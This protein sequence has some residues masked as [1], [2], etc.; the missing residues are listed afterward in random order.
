MELI[1]HTDFPA[2]LLKL[3]VEPEF[4]IRAAVLWK[5]TYALHPTGE[6]THAHDPMPILSDRL[7]TRFGVFHAETFFQ[8]EDVDVVFAGTLRTSIPVTEANI[9]LRTRG[10]EHRMR[11]MGNRRWVRLGDRL[12]PSEPEPFVEMPI[13][14]GRAYGGRT[15]VDGLQQVF[16]ANPEGVGY[17]GSEAQADNMPLPNLLAFDAPREIGWDTP[18][19]VVGWGPYPMHWELRARE[20]I[21]PQGTPEAPELPRLR[22]RLNNNAHPGL[23]VAELHPGDRLEFE[24]VDGSCAVVHLPDEV[25]FVQAQV[26]EVVEQCVGRIDGVVWWHDVGRLT[27]THRA[28][29]SYEHRRNELRRIHVAS[30]TRAEIYRG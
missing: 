28:F 21:I 14:Y 30:G 23:I 25:L 4:P 3:E 1:N 2:R 18:L 7:E 11:V 8:K 24:G 12:V 27:V 20:G 10:L 17:Y 26:G 6:V 13:T 22:P 15:E 29:F 16:A 19:A 9:V 5:A